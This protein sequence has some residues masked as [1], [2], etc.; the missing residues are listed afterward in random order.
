MGASTRP[1]SGAL[2][3]KGMERYS[4][5]GAAHARGIGIPGARMRVLLTTDT[6]GG[7]WTF[8]RE[9]TLYLLQ[10]RHSVMLVSFG[11][12]PS[13][14]QRDW[15]SRAVS[16]FGDLFWFENSAAPLEW[17]DDNDRAY[18]D[19]ARVLTEAAARFRPDLL[20][21]NQYCFGR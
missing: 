18:E 5:T 15:A 19:G 2:P 21:S 9:L 7:V 8:T 17:M 6:I 4:G 11:R 20:H 3:G 1:L 10:Q 12:E 13:H 16:E 14:E